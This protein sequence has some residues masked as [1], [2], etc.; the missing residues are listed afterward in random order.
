MVSNFLNLFANSILVPTPSV[1]ETITGSLILI[2]LISNS[3]PKPPIVSFFTATF[4]FLTFFFD[5]FDICFTNSLA[6]D[7][8][9]LNCFF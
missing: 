2:L 4:V 9:Y 5:I 8:F 6:N 3:E 7:N 1:Q